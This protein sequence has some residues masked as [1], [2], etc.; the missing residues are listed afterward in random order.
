VSDASQQ[1]D[2]QV[3]K[4]QTIALAAD[5]IIQSLTDQALKVKTLEGI[6][7]DLAALGTR[8]F[9]ATATQTFVLRRDQSSFVIRLPDIENQASEQFYHF[10]FS[11]NS[12]AK[13][14]V[15][16]CKYQVPRDATDRMA[17]FPVHAQEKRMSTR[18]QVFP[19]PNTPFEL[20]VDYVNDDWIGN[21]FMMLSIRAARD[22]ATRS[23][24]PREP[25]EAP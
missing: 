23:I 14:S 1:M 10:A 19:I 6:S 11:L 16:K 9:R 20:A 13:L 17:E 21:D 3:H 25:G 22:S 4:I 2:A 5:N 18:E 7:S 24:P 15:V 12:I 8:L